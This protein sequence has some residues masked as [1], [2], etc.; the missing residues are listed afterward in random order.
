MSTRTPILDRI[1]NQVLEHLR[2][3]IAV[4]DRPK[5]RAIFD[6]DLHL[7]AVGQRFENV[8]GIAD[9]HHNIGFTRGWMCSFISIR[10]SDSRS[11][12]SLRMRPASPLMIS[13]KCSRATGSSFGMPAERI[14]KPGE[15]GE[16]SSQF[17][18]GIGNK[19]GAQ[20]L[21]AAD[22]ADIVDPHHQEL[23]GG[24]ADMCLEMPLIG[25]GI[26]NATVSAEP[27]PCTRSML[28][29]NSGVRSTDESR[30]PIASER[31]SEWVAGLA[32]TTRS[33]LSRSKSGSL[34]EL[35]MS[36]A[37]SGITFCMFDEVPTI[38]L[39]HPAPRRTPDKSQPRSGL[40]L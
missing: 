35:S 15:R 27:P 40:P 36:R 13:R 7:L 12:I 3:F 21:G 30:F 6:F 24:A 29:S 22:F 39:W 17:M 4:A 10:L 33:A 11:S 8:G 1:V 20:L 28:S 25:T 5:W 2:E 14:D 19:I 9:D 16:R 34:I 38:L 32:K 31:I 37:V 23:R 18:A 26:V